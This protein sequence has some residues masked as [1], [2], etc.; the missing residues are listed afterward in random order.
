MTREASP[1]SLT[2]RFVQLSDDQSD[3]FVYKMP[4]EWWS[5]KYEYEWASQF[6]HESQVVLDAACGVEHPLDGRRV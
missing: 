6:C 4:G 3:Y 5:R 1:E 2:S